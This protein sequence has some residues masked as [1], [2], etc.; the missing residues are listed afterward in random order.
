MFNSQTSLAFNNHEPPFSDVRV[1]HALQMAIDLE[2][3]RDS[4][5]SGFGEWKPMGP[6]GPQ[7][8]GYHN[9]FDTWPEELQK[10][11]SYDPEGAERLLDV[12]ARHWAP[13][14]E[15]AKC[16][17]AGGPVELARRSAPGRADA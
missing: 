15:S 2:T 14:T 1:R 12:S 9:A 7:W 13:Q 6:I 8:V 16:T 5:F 11:W 3:I 10:L 4:Y 17:E